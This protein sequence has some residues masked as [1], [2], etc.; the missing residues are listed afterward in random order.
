[1]QRK[2][3]VPAKKI[4]LS[5]LVLLFLAFSIKAQEHDPLFTAIENGNLEQVKSLVQNGANIERI[6]ID[7]TYTNQGDNSA[8]AVACANGAFD[9]AHYLLDKGAKPECSWGDP[10]L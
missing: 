1:M 4:T 9:I 6:K 8:L 3:V 7:G 10:A 5:L 2:L